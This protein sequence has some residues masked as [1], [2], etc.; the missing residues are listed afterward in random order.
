MASEIR[1]SLSDS[2]ASASAP[3]I[4]VVSKLDPSRQLG[5]VGVR[6]GYQTRRKCLSL[7]SKRGR[8]LSFSERGREPPWQH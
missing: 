1:L 6:K 8:E 2:L 5:N 4:E 7:I 3:A